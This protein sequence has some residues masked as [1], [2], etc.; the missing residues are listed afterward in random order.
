LVKGVWDGWIAADVCEHREWEFGE[1][2]WGEDFKGDV[3]AAVFVV[4]Y[5]GIG[6]GA[7]QF[8][9]SSNC[10]YA[11]SGSGWYVDEE[12][13]FALLTG[14]PVVGGKTA[15][16]SRATLVKRLK[17]LTDVTEAGDPPGTR[18]F[19]PGRALYYGTLRGYLKQDETPFYSG[20][21]PEPE[22]EEEEE[23]GVLTLPLG[24]STSI[25]GEALF[26][27]VQAGFS[28]REGGP[29]SVGTPFRYSGAPAVDAAVF[30]DAVVAAE[31]RLDNGQVVRGNV[32]LNQI[33]LQLNYSEGGGVPVSF[34]GVFTG[35]VVIEADEEDDDDEHGEEG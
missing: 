8:K 3:F 1:C 29:V 13:N 17:S 6:D 4:W 20:N 25:Q 30:G 26:E 7:T 16:V 31:L 23:A 27:S 34:A 24:L 10:V 21:A 2:G 33:A 9:A 28:F 32:I 18:Y 5:D 15:R 14:I 12:G 35:E 22:E 19:V 11:L